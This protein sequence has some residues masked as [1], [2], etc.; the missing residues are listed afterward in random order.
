MSQGASHKTTQQSQQDIQHLLNTAPRDGHPSAPLEVQQTLA[1]ARELC[2]RARELQTPQERRQQAE[3]DRVMQ[4][5]HDKATLMQLTDQAFR[6][7]QAQR[8]ADQLIHI[9]DVQ[10][11]PRFFSPIDR[12]LLLGFQSFGSYLPGVAMP[13]V[14]AH[15]Q[16]ETA[17]VILPAERDLLAEHLRARWDEGLRMNVNYLGEA[18]LGEEDARRRLQGYLTAL[19]QPEIEVISVKISTIYSQISTV[20]R[21]HTIDTLCDRLELLYRAATK[22]KFTRRDGTVVPKFVYLDMEEYRDKTLT[23]EVFMQTLDRRG[24]EQARAGIALQAYIPDSFLTQQWI[25][26]WARNRVAAGGSPVTIRIVKGANMEAERVEA[27]LRGWPQAPYKTKLETDANYLRMLEEGLR[28]ENLAAVHLGIASHNLFTLSYALVL[29]TK[30]NALNQ[31]QFEMLEGM[32]NHQRRALFELTSN[33][34]LYAPACKQEDFTNAIGYLVRRLD[35]NTGPDNYLRYAFNIEVDRP[36]WNTL[37]QQFVEAYESRNTVSSAPRR[38]QNRAASAAPGSA[39]GSS[40]RATLTQTPGKAGNY[41]SFRNEP[42]TDWSLPQNSQ[43]ASDIA[44]SWHDRHTTNAADVP[45]VLG[46]EQI[47]SDRQLRESLDPSR[48]GTVVARYRQATESDINRAVSVAREDPTGWRRITQTERVATL[49]RVAGELAAA[50]GELMGAMLAEGGKVLTE[51]DPEVS[52]AID[53]CRFYADSADYFR[54]LPGISAT[55]RGVVVV[56]SPW[57]FPLAIPCGGVAAALAAGNNVILKP[58]SDTVLIAYKLCECFWRAG[59]PQTALQFAPCSGGTVGA[60]LVSHEGVDAVILTGGTETA[61]EMLH[62]K[63][64]IHLL[65]ETGGKNATIVTAL[66]DRDQ[67]IK[68][69]L[70]SAFSHSGQKCSATSLL[71]LES[72]V[73]HDAG[74]RAA[75]CDA[76]ESLRVGS[77]WDLPTKIG[78]LIRPPSG[79]LETGLKELEPGEEWAVMPRLN[80]DGNP[81]LIS[82]GIK[83]GVQNNSFTHCTELFGPV[84]GVMEARNLDHAIDLVNATGYGLTSGLE[85]LDDREQQLWC[86]RICAGNLYINRPTTGAIVLRQPFGGI[87]KSSVGPGIKAGSPNYVVPLMRITDTAVEHPVFASED[88]EPLGLSAQRAPFILDASQPAQS[89]PELLQEF[90]HNLVELAGSASSADETEIRDVLS[91]ITNY[92]HWARTEFLTPHDHF[93]LLGEDN[94]RRY[95]PVE[96]LRIRVTSDDT[97]SDIFNRAAAARAVGSR[98]IISSPPSFSGRASKAVSLLE[99]LTH[100][101]AGAIEFIEEDDDSLANAITLG[102]VARIRYAAPDRVPQSIRTAAAASLQ[103]IADTPI[104]RHGRIELL[105]YVREQSVSHIYHRYGNL[106]LRA[107]EPRDEPN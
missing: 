18:L 94:F 48:P 26:D 84:L 74:F 24:L 107:D 105:W 36:E 32:A 82:P 52:E 61:A 17:N 79:V 73:Y 106:G 41:E 27:S 88:A 23:A 16:Q 81:H 78:P 29:A 53:F 92:D 42:D 101:W 99:E 28:P 25:N 55:D 8:S 68:N 70:H 34:L 13:F 96:P 6:S 76:V 45:L 62:T 85:S 31:V 43:W 97:L 103:Y 93:R 95:L 1:L 63:P 98:A 38:T 7:H 90:S 20:A 50:R 100:P 21:A 87:G 4:S 2:R 65:A 12:T 54:N 10:G 37:A 59:V 104:S 58:A 11:V 40:T 71:I 30:A 35:E 56:V 69:V 67:A 91:A 89:R 72:E 46:G 22:A 80:V 19:Q 66:S 44:A 51:S 14:K 5:P 77:A 15:M 75:F 33:M 47:N 102:Q 64:A 57:N 60:K 9:L 3:L 39:G 86:T 83:W 49:Y